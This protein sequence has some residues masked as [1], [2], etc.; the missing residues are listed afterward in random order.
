M[1][2]DLLDIFIKVLLFCCCFLDSVML[3]QVRLQFLVWMRMT[4]NY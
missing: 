1:V 4:L 2:L 3:I